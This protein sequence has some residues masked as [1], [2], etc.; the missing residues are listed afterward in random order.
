MNCE[1]EPSTTPPTAVGVG[2][3]AG[4]CGGR[5][6]PRRRRRRPRVRSRRCRSP[7]A[8]VRPACPPATA[9]PLPSLSAQCSSGVCR[10][11]SLARP[12][13]CFGPCTVVTGRL[14]YTAHGRFAVSR[15]CARTYSPSQGGGARGRIETT[16]TQTI[17]APASGGGLS[18]ISGDWA[19]RRRE[20]REHHPGGTG[21]RRGRHHLRVPGWSEPSYLRASAQASPAAPHPGAARAGGGAH[22]GRY[23][24]ATGRPAVVFA[25]SGPAR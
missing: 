19:R 22:G 18:F 11:A 16:G 24:R 6:R 4:A 12:A 5:V 9:D 17:K 15:P 1:A 10:A 7:P 23:A 14:H 20:R 21:T 13:S 25:T 8:A 2:R 3:A